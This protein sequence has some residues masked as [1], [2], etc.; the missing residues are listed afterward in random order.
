M[1]ASISP[2]NTCAAC[3]SQFA[4]DLLACPICRQLVHAQRLRE[5]AASAASAEQNQSWSDAERI[6]SEALPL[7]P[8]GSAQKQAVQRKLMDL[9]AKI[10]APALKPPPP[11]GM[12]SDTLGGKKKG[13]LAGVLGTLALLA[14]KFKALVLL[15][16]SKFKLL[17]LG[18]SKISTFLSMFASFGVYWTLYGWKFA[19][20]LVL[21]IYVHE[22]GHVFELRRI[23]VKASAPL[24][25]P[26]LG[27]VIRL[28]QHFASPRD[29]A[30][31][32][33]AGPLWGL[34]AALVCFGVAFGLGGG[35]WSVVDPGIWLAIGH[36]GAFINLFNLLPVWQL[37]GGRAFNAMNVGQRWLAI[38]AIAGAFA[39]THEGLLILIGIGA[40]WRAFQF[41]AATH[42]DWNATTTYCM[43]IFV[44]AGLTRLHTPPTL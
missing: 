9:R 17:L 2:F 25:I 19:L 38:I 32:G 37:D 29:D 14:W 28:Q 23:G 13:A 11:R 16:L 21:S 4:P 39:M 15:G 6:W 33:L 18:L 26:G 44:L 12:P 40:I 36:L 1:S 8:P 5:L 34:A 22:M 20:G 43:L 7:L 10:A 41:K 30:R 42:S 3:G 27:A 24:F 35:I 31:V